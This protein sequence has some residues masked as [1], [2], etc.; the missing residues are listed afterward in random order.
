MAIEKEEKPEGITPDV[1]D[2]SIEEADVVSAPAPVKDVKG[3]VLFIYSCP[4]SSPVKFRM[5]YSTG[6]RGVQQEATD[7]AG[8]EIVGKVGSYLLR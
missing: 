6:V 3:R 4:S 5:V 1:K 2:L 7:K 8:M